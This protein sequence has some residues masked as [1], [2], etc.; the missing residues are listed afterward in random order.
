MK[1]TV[2]A[3]RGAFACAALSA[4]VIAISLVAPNRAAAQVAGGNEVPVQIK[5]YW[6][7]GSGDSSVIG[8]LTFA[9]EHGKQQR[10]FAVTYARS[11]DPPTIGT[12]IFQQA[13]INPAYLVY[14][15]AKET[16]AFFGAP[17]KKAMVL[18]GIYWQLQ[19][20][21]IL[22]AVKFPDAPA[23]EKAAE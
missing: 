6:G 10:S 12:D 8:N 16:S 14:G 5:G 9:D 2:P 20:D 15:R 18:T 7:D 11:Y 13:A 17:D 23:A 4:L 21:L 1:R 19:G 22:G 3:A